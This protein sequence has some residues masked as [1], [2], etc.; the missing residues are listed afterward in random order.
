MKN[1]L[2]F[3]AG[4]VLGSAVT[5]VVVRR[6]DERKRKKEIDELREF[7]KN[8]E[9]N[10]DAGTTDE[11]VESPKTESE[12]IV[13]QTSNLDPIYVED[14]E[15][16]VQLE[17]IPGS[18]LPYPAPYIIESDQFG[19]QEGYDCAG[20][21]FYYQNGYLIDST[22][23]EVSFADRDAMIGNLLTSEDALDHFDCE[24]AVYI[25]N[26][27]LKTDFEILLETEDY[28][29]PSINAHEDLSDAD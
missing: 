21:W 13:S 17:V 1:L 22:G 15:G 8:R 7:Y 27:R 2:I 26:E 24:S 4:A 20:T 25:R 9:E 28:K 23:M 3:V 18:G 14:V 10:K 12:N 16:D 29:V 19:D 6:S 11:H 5:Y